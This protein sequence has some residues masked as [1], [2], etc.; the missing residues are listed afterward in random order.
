MQQQIY[1]TQT[2][3]TCEAE[4]SGKIFYFILDNF[5]PEQLPC[6]RLQFWYNCY[7][8]F[9]SFYINEKVFRLQQV[10]DML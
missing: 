4:T 8:S 9:V 2:S 7:Y 6:L 10:N 3:I 1:K 5:W